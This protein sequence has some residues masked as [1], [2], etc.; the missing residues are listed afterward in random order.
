MK[1]DDG[2]NPQV[3]MMSRNG[4]IQPL[5]RDETML[6]FLALDTIEP[7]IKEH[8]LMDYKCIRD[9]IESLLVE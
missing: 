2:F 6:I 8:K 9:K 5:D 3:M 1:D 4:A 7:L